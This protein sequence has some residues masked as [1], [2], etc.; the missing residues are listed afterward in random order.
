MNDPR[1]SLGERGLRPKKSFGQNFL[2]SEETSSF[3]ADACVP[4][5]EQ[6]QARVL[7]LGAGTGALT[8][9]LLERAEHV[10]AVE[11]DRDLLPVL[12][13]RFASHVH[14]GK[15]TLVEG[16]AKTADIVELLGAGSDG[17]RVLSGNLPY[18]L[19]GPLLVRAVEQARVISRAVFLLQEEV[20]ERLEAPPDTK[21]YG[22]LTVFVSAAFQVKRLRTVGR[23]CFFP[24]PEVTSAI[25]ML[26]PHA[27]PRA[28]ETPLFRSLVK[29]AFEQRRKTL[30]NA[31]SRLGTSEEIARA[32]VD[33]AVDLDARGETLDVE[34]FARM[35]AKLAQL[36][37]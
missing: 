4:A 15:L 7:E 34:A 6:G 31:W 27:T 25:V 32:A 1:K 37:A 26:T 28:E 22:A 35:A 36:R 11:R 2:T 16:D 14:A 19:T 23:N 20:V 3:I 24:P 30:R 29:G 18:Q 5:A 13:E 12:A 10:V 33:A 9:P 17:R 8:A 21:I